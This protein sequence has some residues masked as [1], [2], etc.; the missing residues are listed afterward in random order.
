[1]NTVYSA[2]KSYDTLQLHLV[3]A[4]DYAMS[5]LSGDVLGSSFICPNSLPLEQAL[6][7][8]AT[9]IAR[10]ADANSHRDMSTKGVTVQ[11]MMYEELLTASQHEQLIEKV[12]TCL[13]DEA[14]HLIDRHQWL[15][16]N[17]KEQRWI[18]ARQIIQYWDLTM[19]MCCK[20]DLPQEAF[21][22]LE[23]AVLYG[24]AMGARILGIMQH[25]S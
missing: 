18:S 5:S 10:D 7:D 14:L 8:Q 9:L 13:E 6:V 2:S 3:W 1:M 20:E 16:L 11:P 24:D 17:P 23:K 21:E 19:R 15:A 12:G 25:F 22:E 4:G